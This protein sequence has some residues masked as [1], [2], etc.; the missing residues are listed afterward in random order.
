MARTIIKYKSQENERGERISTNAVYT[1]HKMGTPMQDAKD[2]VNDAY[3]VEKNTIRYNQVTQDA[4]V[5]ST[6]EIDKA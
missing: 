2:S 4:I 6:P 3:S 5:G 1:G